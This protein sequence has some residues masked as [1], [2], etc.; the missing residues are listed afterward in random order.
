MSVVGET[1]TPVN[2]ATPSTDAQSSDDNSALIGGIV[3][4]VLGLLLVGGLIAF[5]VARRTRKVDEIAMPKTSAARIA[6]Q[7]DDISAVRQQ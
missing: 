3:G 7:Y 4:G 2:V 5:L 1:S 6:A